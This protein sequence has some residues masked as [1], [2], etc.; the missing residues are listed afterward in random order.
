M[1]QFCQQVI[2][3]LSSR[4]KMKVKLTILKAVDIE[5]CMQEKGTIMVV[6]TEDLQG[7]KILL[8]RS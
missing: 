8:V 1:S 7:T 3:D 2:S 5:K 6:R 4:T